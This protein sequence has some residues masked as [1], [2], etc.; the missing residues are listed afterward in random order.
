MF[1]KLYTQLSSS[2]CVLCDK[3]ASGVLD[4]CPA[5]RLNLPAN[6]HCCATCALP[7]QPTT[8]PEG[9]VLRCGKCVG[10]DGP[11]S[12]SVIPYLYRPP[13]DFMIQRLKYANETKFGR[14]I[15]EL[16]FQSIDRQNAALPDLLIPVPLHSLRY[17]QRG[18]NQAHL[19]A[20]HLSKRLHI[21]LHDSAVKRVIASDHQA[22]L[23][24]RARE[25]NMRQAFSVTTSINGKSIAIVDDVYTTG[26][27]CSTL[28][29]SLLASGAKRVDAWAF[30]RTP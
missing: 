21:P 27:T 24:A 26:A 16:L 19:I 3:Q 20:L 18:F 1:H 11:I 7:L 14:L 30:A 29:K 28:A 15:G 2:T 23:G 22:T 12:Q 5:C 13:A 8:N 4:L 6:T 10:S 17:R 25:R 9:S